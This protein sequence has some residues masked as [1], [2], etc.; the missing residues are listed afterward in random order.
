MV[1]ACRYFQKGSVEDVQAD[2][3]L[4]VPHPEYTPT[5]KSI[6]AVGIADA[7]RHLH[8]EAIPNGHLMHRDIKAANVMLDDSYHPFLGDFGFAKVVTDAE[9]HNTQGRGSYPWMAPEVMKSGDYLLP[10]DVFSYGMLL[11]ELVYAH[12]PF[13][14]FNTSIEFIVHVAEKKEKPDF[15]NGVETEVCN[16]IK[17]C[18]NYKPQSRPSFKQ[19]VNALVDCKFL[20]EGTDIDEYKRFIAENHI[21]K[22]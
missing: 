16:L 13:P 2:I 21:T 6:I 3:M 22:H 10:A 7:M 17:E 8:D 5:K 20:F 9:T 14:Q 4:G 15:I 11:Y 1:Y 18:G 12:P 19:I